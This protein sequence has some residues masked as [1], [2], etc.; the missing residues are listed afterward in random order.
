MQLELYGGEEAR[1]ASLALVLTNA[2]EDWAEAA[3]RVLNTFR[4]QQITS[5]DLRITCHENGIQPH[6]NKAWGALTRLLIKEGK[7]TPTGV[8]VKAVIKTSHSRPIAVYEVN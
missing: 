4:G 8:Y 2:G 7:L 6:N 1:D 3:R 5:E